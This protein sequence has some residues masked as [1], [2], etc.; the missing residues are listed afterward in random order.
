MLMRH[1]FDVNMPSFISAAM[2][3]WSILF[4]SAKARR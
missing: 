2:L 4:D 3:P 1:D